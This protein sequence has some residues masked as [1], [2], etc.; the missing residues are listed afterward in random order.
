MSELTDS[1]RKLQM[2]YCAAVVLAAGKSERMGED[3][4]FMT[5]GGRLVLG[6][7]L[8]AFEAS[9]LIREIV[10]V[11]TPERVKDVER[12]RMGYRLSKLTSVVFGGETRTRSALNGVM[13]VS[14]QAELICIHDAARPLVTQEVI[15]GALRGAS[16]YLAAAPAVHVKDTLKQAQNGLVTST[17]DRDAMF[18]VQTPQAFR[19]ELIKAALTKAV[20]EGVS[21]SDD[22]AAVEAIGAPVRLT[23]GDEENLKLT[24]PQDL[25]LAEAI[26]K[27]REE[28]AR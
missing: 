15:A 16:L 5:V 23:E 10:L 21:Y 12:V 4:L 28:A 24:T 2:G 7:S 18:A 6:L 1:I 22:C 14:P 19:A 11:T 25:L 17:P 8:S 27:R 13:A 3:K 20:E 26:W 9:P